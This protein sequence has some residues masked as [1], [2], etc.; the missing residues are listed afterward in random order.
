M[1]PCYDLWADE[2]AA[3]AVEYGLIAPAFRSII[4]IVNGFGPRIEQQIHSDQHFAEVSKSRFAD[5][6]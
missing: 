1:I 2:T 4:A 3:T 6:V 5:R